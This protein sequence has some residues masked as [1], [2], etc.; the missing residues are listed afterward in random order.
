MDTEVLCVHLCVSI[1]KFRRLIEV[2]KKFI[3]LL[4]GCAML[5]AVFLGG[6]AEENTVESESNSSIASQT[7]SSV[8]VENEKT[9]EN[10]ENIT[11]KE[12]EE[13]TDSDTPDSVSSESSQNEDGEV[14]VDDTAHETYEFV[15][16]TVTNPTVAPYETE[17]SESETTTSEVT[18]EGLK[19][20]WKPLIV[21]S[22][23]DGKELNF[24]QAFGSAYS[25]YG[26]SLEISD[27]G[28]FTLSMGASVKEANSK[29]TFTLSEN[30]LIVTYSD[31]SPDTFLYIPQYQNHQ[32]IKT[33]IDNF[34][35][36]FY[37]V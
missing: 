25:Q 8:S 23:A 11:S 24:N 20:S 27:K 36:Y 28:S 6:C 21:T 17:N 31:G 4:I 34:Y 37:K 10:E 19:G 26:G 1:R 15:D 3:T 2:M 18:V 32:V 7:T 33:Q 16:E 14:I 35:V 22:V 12:S 5:S 30:N 13:E 9:S 29:G